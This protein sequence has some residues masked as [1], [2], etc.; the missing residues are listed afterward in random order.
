MDR[1]YQPHE[2]LRTGRDYGRVMQRQQKA[3]G[4][5][6]VVLAAQRRLK[7]GA[8]APARVGIMVS[9]KV[10]KLSVRRHQLKRW[11]RELFRTELKSGLTGWD[12]VV[13][14]R[15]DPPAAGRRRLDDDI[16]ALLAKALAAGEGPRRTRSP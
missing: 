4:R 10:S 6:V 15:S 9:T 12:V 16:R 11:V 7:G 8:P 14:F 13:L 2:R 3:A 1:G 5:N